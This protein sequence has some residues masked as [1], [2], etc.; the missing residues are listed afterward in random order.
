MIQV[1]WVFLFATCATQKK[2]KRV[3]SHQRWPS[4]SA[5]SRMLCKHWISIL[6]FKAF[7]R[8]EDEIRLGV[9]EESW[10]QILQRLQTKTRKVSEC[11]RLEQKQW[12]WPDNLVCV[13]VCVCVCAHAC[14]CVS[15]RV[16]VC[17]CV[18]MSALVCVCVCVWA[19]GRWCSTQPLL[20][21]TVWPVPQ[22]KR[23]RC[24]LIFSTCWPLGPDLIR[25][26]D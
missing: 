2:K 11:N 6:T 19:A 20:Y 4:F 5:I 8:S 12:P 7:K 23:A 10:L 25:P 26:A 3:L 14:V 21:C 18:C 17:V 1:F 24:R 13:C 9:R 22:L 16:C 15:T